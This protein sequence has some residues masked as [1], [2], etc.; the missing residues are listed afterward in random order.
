[1][2]CKRNCLAVFLPLL[3][4]HPHYSSQKFWMNFAL[5]LV[6]SPVRG[7]IYRPRQQCSHWGSTG[8]VLL[9]ASN[10]QPG[11]DFAYQGHLA[12]GKT[13]LIVPNWGG[14][15]PLRSAGSKSQGSH[16]ACVVQ[17]YS[18][19]PGPIWAEDDST[20]NVSSAEVAETCLWIPATT[21]RT[22]LSHSSLQAK[23]TNMSA[24]SHSLF[25][26][27]LPPF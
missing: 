2:F 3:H 10:S 25:K 26:G 14:G 21:R 15:V 23:T 1:M 6:W 18:A 13:Y 11:I 4:C 17:G 24:A 9:Q 20:P 22:W 5:D 7:C 16:Q 27:L 19:P 12:M 8:V